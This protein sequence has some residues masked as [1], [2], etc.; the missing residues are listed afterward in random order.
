MPS[1]GEY[2]FKFIDKLGIVREDKKWTVPSQK[3]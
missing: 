3:F 2:F 1:F